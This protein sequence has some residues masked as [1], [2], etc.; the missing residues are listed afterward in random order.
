M[1]LDETRVDFFSLDE[2]SRQLDR[3]LDEAQ[4]A[5]TMLTTG[6][7]TDRPALG[8]FH[9]AHR[10]ADVHADLRAE[11]LA[12][13]RRLVSALTAAQAGTATIMATY[14]AG[15]VLNHSDT[16]DIDQLLGPGE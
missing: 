12:R 14:R 7:G 4:A 5:L 10:T 6:T 1:A 16:R 13:L 15:E 3:R 8:G 9:D 2:F 11:Y